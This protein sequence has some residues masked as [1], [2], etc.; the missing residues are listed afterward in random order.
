M[1]RPLPD[2]DL[3]AC[4]REALAEARA[5]GEAGEM[6]C[7]AVIVLEGAVV[8]RGRARHRERRTQLA[9]AELEALIAG[10][11]AVATRHSEC[12]LVATVE[13]CPLCLGAAVMADVPHI[14][15]AAY[16]RTAGI[17]ATVEREPYVRR[18]IDTYRGGVLEAESLALIAELDPGLLRALGPPG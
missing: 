3:E 12:V 10:G 1:A 8:G 5:A 15:F 18:H 4:M 13:P 2:F 7:G 11:E 9:H 6:P 14:V 17:P 16:D